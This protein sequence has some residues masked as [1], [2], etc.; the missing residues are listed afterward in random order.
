MP[1][2]LAPFRLVKATPLSPLVR[3]VKA[4]RPDE[5][6]EENATRRG[7]GRKAPLTRGVGG[8]NPTGEGGF[9]ARKDGGRT[10][11]FAGRIRSPLMNGGL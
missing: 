4:M 5:G 10:R 7:G 8:S 2:P 1:V 6:V 3:G 11:P 9:M